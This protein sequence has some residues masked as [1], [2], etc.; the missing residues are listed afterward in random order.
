MHVQGVMDCLC[1]KNKEIINKWRQ[2]AADSA[3]HAY[4]SRAQV[5][6][7]DPGVARE[8]RGIDLQPMRQNQLKE[9]ATIIGLPHTGSKQA[10]LTRLQPVITSING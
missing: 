10:L 8:L 4:I 7:V 5:Q 2:E 3:I 9:L 1:P 6:R